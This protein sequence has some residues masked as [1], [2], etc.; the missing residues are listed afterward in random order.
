MYV[1][2]TSTDYVENDKLLRVADLKESVADIVFKS[3][4]G[5]F[6]HV[7]C[8]YGGRNRR[9]YVQCKLS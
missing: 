3:M 4:P 8:M 6:R 2:V 1:R 9:Y 5:C 7:E